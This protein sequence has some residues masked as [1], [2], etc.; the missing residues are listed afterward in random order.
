MKF[1]VYANIDDGWSGC[2]DIIDDIEAAHI[3]EAVAQA[4]S[5]YGGT[6]LTRILSHGDEIGERSQQWHKPLVLERERLW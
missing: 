4:K 1:F 5:R 3:G 2:D 6:D